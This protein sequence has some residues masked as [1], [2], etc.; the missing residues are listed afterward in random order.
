MTIN[1]QEI[2][3]ITVWDDF[4]KGDKNAYEFIYRM[5]ACLLYI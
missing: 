4:R 5:F 3:E 1:H 2:D